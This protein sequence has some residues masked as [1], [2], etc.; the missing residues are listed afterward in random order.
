MIDHHTHKDGD[1]SVLILHEPEVAPGKRQQDAFR[2]VF[3][4]RIAGATEKRGLFCGVRKLLSS[5]CV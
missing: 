3:A 5:A 1:V 4:S 2:Q